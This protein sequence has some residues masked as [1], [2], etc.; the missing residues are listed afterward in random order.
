MINASEAWK[1]THEKLLLPE[2]FL[3]ILLCIT[4]STAISQ[5]TLFATSGAEFSNLDKI[6][7]NIGTPAGANYAT[8]EHNLWVLNGT[9]TIMP[10]SGPYETPG[11]VSESDALPTV[12]LNLPI[13]SE[14]S[15]IPGFTITW[16]SEHGDY[17]TDFTI[18]VKRGG[19]VIASKTVTGNTSNQSVVDMVVS[20]YDFVQVR[21][22]NWNLPDRRI[23]IDSLIPGHVLTFDKNSILSYTH[24]QSGDLLTG[25]LPK[26]SI[27]FA[28][29]NTDGRWNPSNPSGLT[30]YLSERQEVIVRYGM[31]VN[32]K[33]EW[34]KAGTFYMSEWRAP[35]NGLEAHFVARDIFEFLLSVPYKEK[36]VPVDVVT[37]PRMFYTEPGNTE[38]VTTY[39]FTPTEA[40]AYE[41][42][43]ASDNNIYC[44]VR[45]S[46]DT[47]MN[48]G[49]FK[50]SE[51]TFPEP[52]T[53]GD[54]VR[55]ALAQ[56]DTPGNFSV[57]IHPYMEN[58][59]A[60]IGVTGSVAEIVQMCAN[61]GNCLMWQDR[62]GVL[63]I[64]PIVGEKNGYVIPQWLSYSHPE[65]ELSK[66]LKGVSVTHN[67]DWEDYI[68]YGSTGED[69]TVNNPLVRN[70]QYT[71]DWVNLIYKPRQSV[72]GE[73][74][75]DPRLDLFDVVQ[76]ESKY[77]MITPVMLTNI[78][79]T[80]TGAFKATYTGREVLEGTVI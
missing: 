56:A 71:A 61:A 77:G 69:V 66:P 5:G 8:L 7:S 62:E 28:V 39:G 79:Y 2:S 19:T 63:N 53:L 38:S 25:E 70:A 54:L 9:K 35:S 37:L 1:K 13:H 55:T 23:R 29:D 48:V 12:A 57:N 16:S 31:D 49:W 10:D 41:E 33:T 44:R 50:Y 14:T 34:I 46:N 75:A 72:S 15:S 68:S 78:K 58:T 4:D 45:M 24:E 18:Q 3:E 74:R 64:Q 11:Y 40:V 76:V 20:S 42:T 30:R 65:V 59:L 67:Y 43:Q 17:P 26:N 80:Y 52:R 73:F 36:G 22:L 51:L 6:T 21:V 60:V 47:M 32:G 27:E